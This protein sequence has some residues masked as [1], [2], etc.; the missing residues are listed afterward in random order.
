MGIQS[1]GVIRRGRAQSCTPLTVHVITRYQSLSHVLDR[2]HQH[3]THAPLR[4]YVW[5]PSVGAS[6]HA[7]DINLRNVILA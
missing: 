5:K 3:S 1:K 2:Y 7:P 4:T 6:E